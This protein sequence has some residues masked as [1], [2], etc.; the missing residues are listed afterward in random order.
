MTIIRSIIFNNKNVNLHPEYYFDFIWV[1]DDPEFAIKISGVLL[2]SMTG[3][4]IILGGCS[5]IGLKILDIP[6]TA[7][8]IFL[9]SVNLAA[10]MSTAAVVMDYVESENESFLE[11][12]AG[13][14]DV[15]IE[16]MKGIHDSALL[17]GECLFGM[18]V[19]E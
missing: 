5:C 9:S 10:A 6:E 2:I 13:S 4:S 15:F 18:L 1:V 3:I 16:V 14:L 8:N 19:A 17:T 7:V 12:S 11:Y